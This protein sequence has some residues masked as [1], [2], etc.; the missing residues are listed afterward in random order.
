M[1]R[2]LLP[3][4]AMLLLCAGDAGCTKDPCAKASYKNPEAGFCM[5]LPSG[6]TAGKP[7]VKSYETRLTFER[8][9]PYGFI[10]V[11]WSNGQKMTDK[12]AWIQTM[13]SDPKNEVKGKGDIPATGGKFYHVAFKGEGIHQSDVYVQGPK[14]LFDCYVNAGE[15][16]AQEEVD[17]CKTMAA[18]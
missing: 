10:V 14:F 11:S 5:N 9:D 13:T 15:E 17:A 8:K 16:H 12:E 7:E 6:F 18:M 3:G 2:T 4:L 1:K